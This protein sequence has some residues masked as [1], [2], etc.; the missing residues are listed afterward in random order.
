M[1]ANQHLAPLIQPPRTAMAVFKMMPEGTLAEVIDNQLYMSPAPNP[2]HQRV[3][4][5]LSSALFNLVDANNLGEV[6]S[7]PTDLYLDDHS[8]AVQPDIFYFNHSANIFVGSEGIHGTPDLIVEIL[9]PGNKNYDLRKK[10]DLYEKFGV[11]E[12]WIV[13]PD[14]KAAKGFQL[15]NRQFQSVGNFKGKIKSVLLN[16]EFKF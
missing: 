9:S 1:L 10:K 3:S 16:E 4:I 5:R 2:Y 8:N 7:A 14:T 13:D 15:I 12:Y 11:K 6:F